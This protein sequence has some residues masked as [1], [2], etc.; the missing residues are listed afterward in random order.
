MQ[1][2]TD[3]T[4]RVGGT[5]TFTCRAT[6][7]PMPKIK[8]MRNSNEVDQDGKRYII[9][10]D[11]TLVIT[12]VTEQDVGEYECVA[13]SDMGS[14]KSRKARAVIT[15]SSSLRFTELPESRTVT[16]GSDVTFTCRVDANPLPTIRWWRNGQLIG[17]GDRFSFEQGG[18]VLHIYAVKETDTARY[19]CRAQN[20]NGFAETSADLQV[21]AADSSAPRLTYEPQ[22]I[23]AEPGAVVEVPCRAE[24][25]PKPLIQWKKDGSAL[26]GGRIKISRGGSLYI[27]NVSLQDTG[28]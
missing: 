15:V 17:L 19:V 27:F 13:S 7:D 28:R 10:K 6:G 18:N 20:A 8:W 12:D 26:E 14:T 11:G 3:A 4:V 23:E 1:G 21:V 22:D 24:G 2:P 16:A 5:I 25:R 9:R